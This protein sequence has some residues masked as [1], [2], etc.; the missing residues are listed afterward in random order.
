M[1]LH[2]LGLLFWESWL[3]PG[4]FIR[5]GLSNVIAEAHKGLRT[6]GDMSQG[7]VAATCGS[8]KIMCVTLRGHVAGTILRQFCPCDILHGFQL[9]GLRATKCWTKCCKNSCCTHQKLSAHTGG[10]VAATCPRYSFLRVYTLWF[11]RC[12][13]SPLQVSA[14]CPLSVNNT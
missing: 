12:Y 6:R 11:C 10:H 14:T 2:F 13:M 1:L 9:V 7:H 8:D 5:Q 4:F 3:R